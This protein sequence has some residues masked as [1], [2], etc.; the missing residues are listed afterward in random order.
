[1]MIYFQ[2]A[3]IADL[4]AQAID[5]VIAG[6]GLPHECTSELIERF[7]DQVE[8]P[9]CDELFEAM[10]VTLLSIEPAEYRPDELA[11]VVMFYTLKDYYE[12][13]LIIMC[14][15]AVEA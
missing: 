14:R 2:N 5:D 3:S 15:E 1:M 8:L 4:W 12:T 10:R 7:R 6:G 13:E 11:G 9:T